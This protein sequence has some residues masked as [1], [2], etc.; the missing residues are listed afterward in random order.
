MPSLAKL[1]PAV[2]NLQIIGILCAKEACAK[3]SDFCM[4]EN[5][6]TALINYFLCLVLAIRPLSD[7]S[8]VYTRV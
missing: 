8:T 3:L 1:H 5:Y 4:A 2:E 6:K 7:W